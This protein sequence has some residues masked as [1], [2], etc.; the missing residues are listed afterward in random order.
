MKKLE[1]FTNEELCIAASILQAIDIEGEEFFNSECAAEF[2]K[3]MKITESDAAE[4]AKEF[5]ESTAPSILL[6]NSYGYRILLSTFVNVLIA[7]QKK[8]IASKIM[9]FRQL[10]E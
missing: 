10:E 9:S 3:Q 1:D 5:N 2:K 7:M 6:M 4:M 8:K